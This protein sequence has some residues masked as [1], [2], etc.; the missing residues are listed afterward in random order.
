MFIGS[1]CSLRFWFEYFY[2]EAG[3]FA[4]LTGLIAIQIPGQFRTLQGQGLHL[5]VVYKFS[6]GQ[7]Q[8]HTVHCFGLQ[9]Q[10]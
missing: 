4:I 2:L 8:E 3:S 9:V 1:H 5:L 6:A 10:L 7:G